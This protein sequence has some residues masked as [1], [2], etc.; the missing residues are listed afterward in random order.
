MVLHEGLSCPR[1]PT[2]LATKHQWRDFSGRHVVNGGQWLW[3]TAHRHDFCQCRSLILRCTSAVA[4]RQKLYKSM[5]EQFNKPH[6]HDH[7]CVIQYYTKLQ[8]MYIYVYIYMYM[9]IHNS[10]YFQ[11]ADSLFV[12]CRCCSCQ[13]SPTSELKDDEDFI[14]SWQNSTF[15]ADTFARHSRNGTW[16][17]FAVDT[18]APAEVSI[19]L[20]LGNATH[21]TYR[22]QTT[23]A[24]SPPDIKYIKQDLHRIY[25]IWWIWNQGTL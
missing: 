10:T 9:C 11:C 2:V 18:F 6:K 13:A 12:A 20:G 24:W 25:T 3:F 4:G 21:C 1:R 14:T 17:D 15:T 19:R 8:M 16:P 5:E 22:E 23:S 7:L